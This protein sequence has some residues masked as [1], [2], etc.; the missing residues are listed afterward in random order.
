MK[1]NP[2]EQ[3]KYYVLVFRTVANIVLAKAVDDNRFKFINPRYPAPLK[4]VAGSFP[5]NPILIH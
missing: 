5:W 3:K 2:V 1:A 4:S